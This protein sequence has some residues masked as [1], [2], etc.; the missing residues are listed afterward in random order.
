SLTPQHGS[1]V[2]YGPKLGLPAQTLNGTINGGTAPY[3]VTLYVRRPDN[4]TASYNLSPAGNF[5]FGP[6]QAGDTYFGTTQEGTWRAWFTVTDSGARSATSNTVTWKVVW[7]P[8]HGV[9]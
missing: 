2:L 1:L 6:A 7:Y 3:T 9:P 4:T 8:V 5:S